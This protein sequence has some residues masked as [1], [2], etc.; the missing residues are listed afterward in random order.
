MALLHQATL[1][2]TKKELLEEWLPHQPWSI[3]GAELTAFGSYRLDDPD[4]EVGLEGILL[5]TADGARVQHVPLTYRGAPLEGA[6]DHLVGTTEHS[7]LG[8]RWVYDGAFDPIFVNVLAA[9]AVAGAPGAEEYFEIDGEKVVREPKV[10]VQGSGAPVGA[11]QPGRPTNVDISIVREVGPMP[12]H[13]SGDAVLT[14]TWD[15]GSGI[16]GIVR[17][18]GPR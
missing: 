18:A 8:K 7:V 17:L 12:D 2:P 9:T 3:K 5:R 10:R 1:S 15:G 13:Q 4:G 11:Y 16:V 14:A 6:E